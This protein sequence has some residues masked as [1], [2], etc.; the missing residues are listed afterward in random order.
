VERRTGGLTRQSAAGTAKPRATWKVGNAGER[1]KVLWC[2]AVEDLVCQDLSLGPD[3]FRNTQPVFCSQG[4][5]ERLPFMYVVSNWSECSVQCGL[6]G[7]QTRSVD[8][9]LLGDG[10]VLQVS[11]SYC[12][13]ASAHRPLDERDCG[14]V[15]VCPR[16]TSADWRQV[17]LNII[18]LR[19]HSPIGRNAQHSATLLG[20]PLS[21]LASINK[22][23]AWTTQQ[24]V[25]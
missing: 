21:K 15:D 11:D 6:G 7:V 5:T 16:W 24:G 14:F 13:Q 10:W 8:C 18:R 25:V 4:K 19:V 22:K 2:T 1:A 17:L 9:T 23:M 20:Y 3:T 12:D